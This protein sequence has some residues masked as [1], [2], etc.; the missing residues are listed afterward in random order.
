MSIH[1]ISRNQIE[2]TQSSKSVEPL[3]PPRA[4]EP[5]PDRTS[6]VYSQPSP[7]LQNQFPRE[8]TQSSTVRD[9]VRDSA[10]VPSSVWSDVSPPDS[11][12]RSY[13]PYQEQ[14]HGSPDV[15]PIEERSPP[16][17]P[18]LPAA[19]NRS[20][21][22]IPKPAEGNATKKFWPSH[23]VMPNS[24]TTRW[25]EYSGEPTVS[26]KGQPSSV[27]PG[28]HDTSFKG[29]H[30]GH[31]PGLDN[32]PGQDRKTVFT[33]LRERD[34]AKRKQ[35]MQRIRDDAMDAPPEREAWKGA[36]GRAA[37]P[38]PVRSDPTAKL[39]PLQ[40]PRNQHA[41]NPDTN[42]VG[43][44]GASELAR[45]TVRP[46]V[47]SGR[48]E[49]IKPTVPLKAGTNTPRNMSP[50]TPTYPTAQLD[51]RLN[52]RQSP[53][54]AP[55]VMPPTEASASLPTPPGSTQRPYDPPLT[56][57]QQQQHEAA[58]RSNL[59]SLDLDDQPSS[60]F[61]STTYATTVNESP[62]SSPRA[63]MDANAPPVP[64]MPSP[65]LMRKRPVPA[66][67]K[68]NTLGPVSNAKATTRKP[69]PSDRGHR[70]SVDSNITM[71][72]TETGKDLPAIPPAMNRLDILNNELATLS[73]RRVKINNVLKDLNAV[74]NPTSVA[75]D[76]A[77][78][79]QTKASVN[80]LEEELADIAREEHEIGLKA[81]RARRKLDEL[82]GNWAGEGVLWVKRVT[83]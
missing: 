78:R 77:T 22:P 25:D 39:K 65:V 20:N 59:A 82:D 14:T 12:R 35:A 33:G 32:K 36:S 64:Q 5:Y 69:A 17:E 83:S 51:S 80:K 57:K 61:S 16:R 21:L 75:Y 54:S 46:V 67:T 8:S 52:R 28:Q 7:A 40:I 72:T 13:E 50:T 23:Q 53:S 11:P 34:P 48:F 6:S 38:P 30:S 47:P 41:V 73:H 24:Q 74:L 68:A 42:K 9:S 4:A 26:E 37:I 3:Q 70:A 19:R 79:Q 81:M 60:R 45:Q 2:L 10:R 44:S 58:L 76:H 29:T 71:M 49:E 15:S 43:T 1:Y 55:A 31:R 62:N 18:R 56:T 66:A 27:K 63:S